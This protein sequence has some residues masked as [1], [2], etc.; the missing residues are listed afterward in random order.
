[1]RQQPTRVV[2]T[3]VQF[4]LE[5]AWV[6]WTKVQVVRSEMTRG[7]VDELVAHAL[8]AGGR[9][10]ESA[11]LHEKLLARASRGAGLQVVQGV[12]VATQ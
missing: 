10:F 11:R 1:M 6:A 3:C 12:A 5:R 8:H 9:R 4:A 2:Q 7:D